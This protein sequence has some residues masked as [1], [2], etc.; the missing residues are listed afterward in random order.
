MLKFEF[1]IEHSGERAAGL[2]PYSE[3]VKIEVE[4][5]FGDQTEMAEMFRDALAS[6]YDGAKVLTRE[7]YDQLHRYPKEPDRGPM[8]IFTDYEGCDSGIDTTPSEE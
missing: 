1:E 6:W 8:G 7:E 5:G 3:T 2:L 4:Y